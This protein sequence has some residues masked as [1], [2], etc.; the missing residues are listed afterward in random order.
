MQTQWTQ[1]HI[2]AHGTAP[3]ITVKQTQQS[4]AIVATEARVVL[5]PVFI[6]RAESFLF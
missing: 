1:L 6:H 4:S 2:F 3:I 5:Q